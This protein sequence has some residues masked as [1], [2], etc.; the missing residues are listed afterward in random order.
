[1][2]QDFRLHH[3]PIEPE[4]KSLLWFEAGQIDV[5]DLLIEELVFF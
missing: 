1:M 5:F 4:P 2:R 3:S